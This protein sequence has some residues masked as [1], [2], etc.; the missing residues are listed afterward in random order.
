MLDF[1]FLEFCRPG[2]FFYD[3]TDAG[4]TEAAFDVPLP[5]G[6]VMEHNRDWSICHPS[7]RAGLPEQGWKIHVSGTPDT[8]HG[9]LQS[10]V[11]YLTERQ[12]SFKFIRSATVL[13][14]RGSKNSDRTAS[15]KFITIYPRDDLQ[16]EEL[17]H[18]LDELVGGTPGPYILTDLRWKQ[19][20]LYVRYGAYMWKWTRDQRGVMVAAITAPDGSLVPDERRPVF[21]PPAWLEIPPFLE[22]AVAARGRGTLRD[23]PFK[24]R[25]ALHYSNGGGVYRATEISTGR[26]VLLREARPLAGTD[27]AG[28]DAVERMERERWA[29]ERLRGLSCIPEVIDHLVG[30]EHRYLARQFVDG[31]PLTALLTSRHP[32]AT[33]DHSHA[34]RRAYRTWALDV[35][36]KVEQ[37]LDEMH[38][39]GVVFGDLHPANVLVTDDDQ[40]VFIDLETAVPVDHAEPQAL[41]TLGFKAPHHL[42]GPDVDRYALA[43]LKLTLFVPVPQ[44]VPWGAGKVRQ[45][46]SCMIR[47]FDVPAAFVDSIL[48][49]LDPEQPGAPAGYGIAW[50]EAAESS[51]VEARIV[52]SVLG[53]A[54]PDR[55]D[56]LYPGDPLQFMTPGGGTTFAYGAAGVLWALSR[57]GHAVPDDHVRWLVDR[58]KGGEGGD[59]PGFNTGLA[60]L[61]L[62]LDEL[63]EHDLATEVLER[64][65]LQA[66]DRGVTDS[67]A[68][69]RSGLA[70]AVLAH[71]RATGVA[72]WLDAAV[73]LAEKVGHGSR[74][75][76]Q[77]GLLHGRTGP[78]LL[79]VHLHRATGDSAFLTRATEELTRD[80]QALDTARRTAAGLDGTG[81]IAAVARAAV[82]FG[83]EELREEHEKVARSLDCLALGFGL[84]TGRSGTVIARVD[85]GLPVDAH[86][87][88]LGWN[89]VSVQDESV[90]FIGD[91]RFRLS[92]DLATGSA[93][94]L[95]ALASARE[96]TALFPFLGMDLA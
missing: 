31:E 15:G 36:R 93:A 19:G 38:E 72:R 2:T 44:A 83:A 21:R 67:F 9:L 41:G 75:V 12:V 3:T 1:R 78:A 94:A 18:G 68:S 73:D 55:T 61:G 54:T 82:R 29:L 43:V 28:A 88:A 48:D 59:G 23:F 5:D 33:G 65:L 79:H 17:L 57:A 45:L 20:P 76:R 89:A 74:E 13:K 39:R 11:P 84:W 4:S 35:L 81:G 58:V 34:G 70:L 22:E 95:L 77:I 63:G 27:A 51:G 14:R 91:R 42:V 92:T 56:R 64:A 25:E 50:P 62:T 49:R 90:D 52:R 32:Y 71:H 69:G 37:G 26:D 6:W 87:R 7:A 53:N 8:A 80:L 24:I 86:V 66:D 46:V 96:R 30:Y 10:V 40:V 47:D 85:H 60:G 16:T